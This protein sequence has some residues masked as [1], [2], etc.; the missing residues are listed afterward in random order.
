MPLGAR[1]EENLPAGTTPESFAR[2]LCEYI[3]PCTVYMQWWIS[4]VKVPDVLQ[5]KFQ[6]QLQAL[7][8]LP[9]RAKSPLRWGGS[10]IAFAGN[11]Q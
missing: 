2:H 11:T 3:L 4:D 1:G 9:N 6:Y 8:E 10:W 7:S 5:L